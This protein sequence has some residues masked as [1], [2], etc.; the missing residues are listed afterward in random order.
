MV[1][2]SLHQEQP[3]QAGG[4]QDALIMVPLPLGEPTRSAGWS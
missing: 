3:G 1:P 4:N 2:I